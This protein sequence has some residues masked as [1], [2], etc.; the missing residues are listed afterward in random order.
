M[1]SAWLGGAYLAADKMALKTV[2]VTRQEYL[3]YGTAWL[4]KIF[5]GAVLR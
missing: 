5:A 2:Q 4:G 1:K 3:E